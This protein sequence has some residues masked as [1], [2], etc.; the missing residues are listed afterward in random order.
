[1]VSTFCCY[2]PSCTIFCGGILIFWFVCGRGI[3]GLYGSYVSPGEEVPNLFPDG[4]TI[5][6]SHELCMEVPFSPYPHQK[7]NHF[8]IR[9][10]LWCWSITVLYVYIYIYLHILY[11]YIYMSCYSIVGIIDLQRCISYRC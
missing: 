2:E 9:A 7:L 6:Y 3:A 10:I 11:I 5:L 4:C 1:M 8:S